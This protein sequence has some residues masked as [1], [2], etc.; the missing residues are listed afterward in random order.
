VCVCVC[1]CVFS[2]IHPL[3]FERGVRFLPDLDGN[4]LLDDSDDTWS[5]SLTDDRTMATVGLG[6]IAALRSL[7]HM[8]D[9]WP[10]LEQVLARSAATPA[11]L[12][13]RTNV[14][15][16]CLIIDDVRRSMITLWQQQVLAR[17]EIL[18][19]NEAE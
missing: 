5:L 2:Y 6:Q 8:L 19:S 7:Q 11:L 10:G 1:V 16:A 4:R 9:R 17:L 14:E 18:M 15:D 13:A 12:A 3:F